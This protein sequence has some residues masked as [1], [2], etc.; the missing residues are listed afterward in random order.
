MTNDTATVFFKV[1]ENL[2]IGCGL[3]VD[4]CRM[5]I[6]EV[7]DGLCVMTDAKKCIEC[8]NCMR[9]C[10]Q[11]AITIIAGAAGKAAAVKT[12]TEGA[13]KSARAN[14]YHIHDRLTEIVQAVGPRQIFTFEGEDITGLNNFEIEGEPS[15][16]R[17]YT[18]DKIEKLGI[19]SVLFYG[20][21]TAD[22]MIVKP[23][24]EYDIPSFVV[25]W[26]ESDEYIFFVCDLIPND[27]PGRN[28]AY[29]TKY[30]YE[31]LDDIYQTYSTIPGL[32]SSVFHWVRALHS[33][34]LIIGTVE[35]TKENIDMLANCACDYLKAWI[36]IWKKAEP[37]DPGSPYM[38][39]VHERRK[40]IRAVYME[41]DPGAGSL[42][43][44]LGDKLGA[45]T[46][47]IMEP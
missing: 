28:N 30:L 8:G 33:P 23:S 31:P 18:A 47:S 46:A 13:G 1:D 32:K 2:C 12:G 44:V 5:K 38:K 3:C 42:N 43:K 25:D 40:N 14:F 9:A 22:A 6:L 11:K 21:M 10:T 20:M 16:C 29:L 35:K 7:Q 27:D 39:L 37:Q 45:T 24:K 4:D 41:N 26:D 34:Y 17:A 15:Y 19:S 36:E